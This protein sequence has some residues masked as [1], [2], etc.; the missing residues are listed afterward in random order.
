MLP[1]SSCAA[2][3]L[4]TNFIFNTHFLS[5]SVS[6]YTYTVDIFLEILRICF[7]YCFFTRYLYIYENQWHDY[8]LQ[9]RFPECMGIVELNMLILYCFVFSPIF[10]KE[11]C[12]NHVSSSRVCTKFKSR[13][14][15]FL[16][17]YILL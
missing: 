10:G 13:S 5:I 7:Y 11:T 14:S 15:I 16:A 3:N 2:S 8:L 17:Y 4:I 1:L 9:I 12:E 6:V